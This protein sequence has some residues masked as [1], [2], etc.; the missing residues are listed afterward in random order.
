MRPHAIAQKRAQTTMAL[1]P[2]RLALEVGPK[3]LTIFRAEHRMI[4]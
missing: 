3:K 4:C 2:Q 1:G